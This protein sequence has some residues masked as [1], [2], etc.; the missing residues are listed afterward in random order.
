MNSTEVSNRMNG[1]NPIKD[2]RDGA[3]DLK[4]GAKNAFPAYSLSE[5][6]SDATDAVSSRLM[7]ETA[8]VR[9]KA[10]EY[11]HTTADYVKENPMKIAIG[12]AVVGL[13][14]GLYLARRR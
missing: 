2:L 13:A 12:A 8:E 14:T 9:A 4:D 6:F 7:D 5:K 11:Y 3:K 1:K 10:T